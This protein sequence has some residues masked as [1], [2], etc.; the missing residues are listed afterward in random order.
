MT[1]KES[2]TEARITNEQLRNLCKHEQIV[3]HFADETPFFCTKQP[4]LGR[5]RRGKQGPKNVLVVIISQRKAPM[6]TKSTPAERS[7][8]MVAQH[9]RAGNAFTT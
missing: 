5:R 4:F 7:R 9:W 2:Q 3:E 1:K 8:D 6:E